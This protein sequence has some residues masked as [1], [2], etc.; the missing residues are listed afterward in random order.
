MK[1]IKSVSRWSSIV[2]SLRFLFK[3]LIMNSSRFVPV[4]SVYVSKLES[5]E[6]AGDVPLSDT[7]DP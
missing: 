2:R 7:V 4:E 6:S 5:R 3:V 1:L